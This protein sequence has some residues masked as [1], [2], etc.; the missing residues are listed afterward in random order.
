VLALE[1]DKG[2]LN[3]LQSESLSPIVYSLFSWW[4]SLCSDAIVTIARRI[5]TIIPWYLSVANMA[6]RPK[7]I[8]AMPTTTAL[9]NGSVLI[10]KWSFIGLIRFNA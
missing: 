10:S 6:M 3:P 5:P 1:S 8:S 4:S 7:E 9:S 2:P